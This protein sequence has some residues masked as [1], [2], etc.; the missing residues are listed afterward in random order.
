MIGVEAAFRIAA[1]LGGAGGRM[2]FAGNLYD[3]YVGLQRQIE[4]R[5]RVDTTGGLTYFYMQA[6]N[7]KPDSAI[8]YLGFQYQDAGG[9]ELCRR[10]FQP[11]AYE[12][13]FYADETVRCGDGDEAVKVWGYSNVG[14][15]RT[16]TQI[17]WLF[18]GP[19][20]T[21][22]LD[23]SQVGG[24]GGITFAADFEKKAGNG[25]LYVYQWEN[26]SKENQRCNGEASDTEKTKEGKPCKSYGKYPAACGK[27]DGTKYSWCWYGY[28]HWMYGKCE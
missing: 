14:K 17:A 11:H 26:Y 18:M 19:F 2:L 4:V 5:R 22:A 13:A 8:K 3:P 23:R 21:A 9:E 16:G 15:D 7:V 24:K 6:T 25:Q 27:H 10:K 1:A 12:A 28:Q 20:N